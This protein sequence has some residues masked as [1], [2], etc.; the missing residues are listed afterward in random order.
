MTE[1]PERK[2]APLPATEMAP[3][4]I[5]DPSVC[6]PPKS[7]NPAEMSMRDRCIQC[8][9]ANTPAN[10]RYVRVRKSLSGAAGLRTR[11]AKFGEYEGIGCLSSPRPITR[12]ALHIFLH[13]CAHF[14]LHDGLKNG[15]R[16]RYVEEFEAD[17]WAIAKMR[18]AGIP[19]PRSVTT[20]AKAH[21]AHKLERV[22]RKK[23]RRIDPK[24]LAFARS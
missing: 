17:Q 14:V 16:P 9:V 20:R 11:N 15:E 22:K 24:L 18:A 19:V 12:R 7:V 4:T 2:G 5:D 3:K 1:P 23:G 13:E 21:V 10:V 6:D 8:A